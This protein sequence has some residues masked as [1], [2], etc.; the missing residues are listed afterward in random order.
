MMRRTQQQTQAKSY[1]PTESKYKGG[2]EEMYVTYDLQQQTRGKGAAL[3]PKVKRIYIAG[4][5]KDWQVGSFAKKSGKNVHGVKIDYEQS[6][7]G[8]QRK[9]YTA[10]RQG[11]KYAVSP[12][13]VGTSTSVFSQI[14]EISPDAQN[15]QFHG[16]KLPAKYRTALQNVR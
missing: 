4:N 2:A 15:I 11:S 16:K 5:V 1:R 9:A 7:R 14:V 12:A 8:Y 3:Y 10:A 6:R 13:K